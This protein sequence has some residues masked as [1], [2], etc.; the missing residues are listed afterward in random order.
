MSQPR[1]SELRQALVPLSPYLVTAL[2]F[3][4]AVALLS[5]APIGYM[6]DVY[7][8]VLNARSSDTLLMVTF[9]LVGALL[10]SSFLE[11]ARA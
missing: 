4:I 5:L 11:W 1:I 7:G 6:R 2:V 9:I 3:T 10:A 8:P